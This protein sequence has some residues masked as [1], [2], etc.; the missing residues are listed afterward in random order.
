MEYHSKFQVFEEAARENF[1]EKYKSY[2]ISLSYFD[3]KE[4][5]FQFGIYEIYYCSVTF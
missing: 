4:H 3:I 2:D 5:G 1:L